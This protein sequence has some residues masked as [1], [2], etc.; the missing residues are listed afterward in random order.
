MATL[1]ERRQNADEITAIVVSGVQII[2]AC[3]VGA[4]GALTPNPYLQT[5]ILLCSTI[6]LAYGAFLYWVAALRLTR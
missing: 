3:V 6:H 2:G 1:S 4:I 5:V